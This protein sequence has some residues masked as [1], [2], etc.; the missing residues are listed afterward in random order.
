MSL[1]KASLDTLLNFLDTFL[2][3]PQKNTPLGSLIIVDYEI[4]WRSQSGH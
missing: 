4:L 1:K 3:I 2:K